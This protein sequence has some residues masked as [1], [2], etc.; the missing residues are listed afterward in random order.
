[1]ADYQ[2]LNL[3]LHSSLRFF[4][5]ENPPFVGLGPAMPWLK[6][7]LAKAEGD[8][9]LLVFDEEELVSFDPD[10]GPRA[11]AELP[12]P[13]FYGTSAPR[14]KGTETGGGSA[15]PEPLGAPWTLPAGDYLFM[16]WRPA[17][18]EELLEGIEWFA[19]EAWWEGGGRGGG[20]G[21]WLLRILKEDGKMATQL[22]RATKAPPS[23]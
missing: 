22:L 15:P 10:D 18:T 23:A 12:P 17:S 8:E 7:K 14:P 5:M 16:Q 19:R 3:R 9:E 1:M 6:S 13:L 2:L 21:P 20:E 4:G 11:A